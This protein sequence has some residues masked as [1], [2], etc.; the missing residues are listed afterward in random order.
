MAG[1]GVNFSTPDL[2]PFKDA[3]KVVYEKL[4][5]VDLRKEVDAM[6]RA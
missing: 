6:L 3:T 2:T 5:Y 1:L 4:N